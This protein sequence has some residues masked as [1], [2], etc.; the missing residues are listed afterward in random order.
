MKRSIREGRGL[1]GQL[2]MAVIIGVAIVIAGL[3]AAKVYSTFA[4]GI[5][6][7]EA[8]TKGAR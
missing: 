4:Q 7:F 5:A 1:E 6:Q 8:S 2:V 3:A